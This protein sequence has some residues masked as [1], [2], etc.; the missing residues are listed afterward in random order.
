M[1]ALSTVII[2]LFVL[3]VIYSM[4]AVAANFHGWI[5]KRRAVRNKAGTKNIEGFGEAGDRLKDRLFLIS[6]ILAFFI[7]A[8]FLTILLL[9]TR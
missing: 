6:V 5:N 4:A 7:I 8:P 3:V 1:I 9:F 2:F